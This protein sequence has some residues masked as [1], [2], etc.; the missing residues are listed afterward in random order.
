MFLCLCVW[1]YLCF[2]DVPR[3]WGQGSAHLFWATAEGTDLQCEES[4]EGRKFSQKSI[5]IGCTHTHTKTQEEPKTKRW[6][7]IKW[8]ISSRL[9]FRWRG[10]MLK[11]AINLLRHVFLLI[12]DDGGGDGRA[13]WKY[14]ICLAFLLIQSSASRFGRLRPLNGRFRLSPRHCPCKKGY[15]CFFFL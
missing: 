2:A 8:L 15:Y 5:K 13:N 4:E 10:K 14:N 7:M 9:E 1:A 6:E 3:V 11:H 12:R